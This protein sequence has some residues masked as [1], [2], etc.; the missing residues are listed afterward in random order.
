MFGESKNEKGSITIEA[1]ISL[2]AFMFT[3]VTILTIVNIC[4]VQTKIGI[5]INETAKEL[6][7]YSYL[8][9]LTGINGSRQKLGAAAGQT[10][11]E[12]NKIISD[13]N[14]AFTEIQNLGNSTSKVNASDTSGLLDALD[15]MKDSGGKLKDAGTSLKSTM[16]ELAKDPKGVAIGLL[17]VIGD[18]GMNLAMS[19]LVAEPL[20]KEL[21][22]KNLVAQDGGD[23]ESYLKSLGVKP[24]AAGSY[25]DGLDFS[26]STLFPSGSNE[27][28][29]NVSYDVKIIALL[30]VDFS[31][32]FNQTA[33]TQGWFAGE[34]SYRST[35]GVLEPTANSSI[36]T[37]GTIKERSELIRHQGIEEY[38]DEGYRQV[39]GESY[40]YAQVFNAD[41][42]EFIGI[43]SMNPLYSGE[44]EDTLTLADISDTAIQSQIEYLCAGLNEQTKKLKEIE[45]KDNNGNKESVSCEDASHR[46][47]IVVP[48]DSG[49]KERIQAIADSAEKNGVIVEI[50][51]SYGNGARTT[52]TDA[53]GGKGE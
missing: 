26:K 43:N 51:A 3:I 17:K 24:N 9:S 42:N 46:L 25:L 19:R 52:L 41:K 37:E 11:E 48:Q 30:P 2:S 40:Q 29:I 1:T 45:V 22:K 28:R 5:A 53:A 49:L 44:G 39:C 18:D 38:K 35:A 14:T 10:K 20:A 50:Q 7:Q 15:G 23:V 12:T 47:V 16:E 8:Y 32:H 31:F 13:L 34:K 6:S 4:V 21:S 33:V 27:I 36:W